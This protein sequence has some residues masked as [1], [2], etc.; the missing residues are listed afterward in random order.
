MSACTKTIG[1]TIAL[2]AAVT[3]PC[4]TC[5]GSCVQRKLKEVRTR[6]IQNVTA[7]DGTLLKVPTELVE[8]IADGTEPC[9]ACT[10]TGTEVY[11]PAR[12]KHDGPCRKDG[13]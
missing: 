4:R 7:E 1:C 8:E 12:T 9:S 5:H 13:V 11:E 3:G 10:G 6:V 2:A